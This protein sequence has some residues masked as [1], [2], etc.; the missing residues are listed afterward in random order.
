MPEPQINEKTKVVLSISSWYQVVV[1]LGG[2]YGIVFGLYFSLRTDI[3]QAIKDGAQTAAVQSAF[4]EKASNAIL[5]LQLTSM[6]IE[7][8]VDRINRVADKYIVEP[9]DRSAR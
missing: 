1:I 6:R 5:Q 7:T 9:G 2:I 3:T 8:Q 4:Q